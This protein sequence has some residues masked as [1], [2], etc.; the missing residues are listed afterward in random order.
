[1]TDHTIEYL[2]AH[3]EKPFY[4]W[5]HYN[6]LHAKNE[7]YKRLGKRDIGSTPIDLYDA[8]LAFTDDHLGRLLDYLESSKLLENTIVAISAD[9]GEEFLEHGQQFHNGRLYREQT[10]VPLILY[11]PGKQGQ[12]ITQP[13]STID[14]GPTFLRAAGIMPSSGY[15]GVDLIHTATGLTKG[16][17]ILIETPRN[18]PQGDFFAWAIVDGDWRLIYD[19]IGHTFELYNDREDPAEKI[20]LFDQRPDQ[21]KAMRSLLAEWFDRES[22]RKDYRNWARF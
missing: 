12:R 21:A 4:I 15:A 13:V 17:P 18:V 6:D 2:T 22:Q 10:H 5:V 16:R 20:N 11:Y 14:L 3:Q 8:N 7:K 9:H 19:Q 1:L